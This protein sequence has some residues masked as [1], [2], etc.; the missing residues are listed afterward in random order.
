MRYSPVQ[1]DQKKPAQSGNTDWKGFWSILWEHYFFPEHDAWWDTLSLE[2]VEG[3]VI[4]KCCTLTSCCVQRLSSGQ[5]HTCVCLDRPSVFTST[6]T[7]GLNTGSGSCSRRVVKRTD[8]KRGCWDRPE[9][10]KTQRKLALTGLRNMTTLQTESPRIK[11]EPYT[12]THTHTR[13]TGERRSLHDEYQNT[14]ARKTR[15][16]VMMLFMVCWVITIAHLCLLFLSVPHFS[17]TL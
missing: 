4:F 16:N 8:R 15:N 11:R 1:A 7:L 10:L 12:H 6:W 14:R 5:D 13:N 3:F 2:S 9:I 17:I